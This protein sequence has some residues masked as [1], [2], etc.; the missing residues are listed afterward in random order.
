MNKAKLLAIKSF[1][2]TRIYGSRED[3]NLSWLFLQNKSN[4]IVPIFHLYIGKIQHRQFL[5]CFVFKLKQE[6][7]YRKQ[8]ARQLCT[9]IRQAIYRSVVTPWPWNRG[10]VKPFSLN[11]ETQRTV[12]V[13]HPANLCT[14][15]CI[16]LNSVLPIHSEPRK[17][18][19]YMVSCALWSFRII[20]VQRNLYQSKASMRLPI[21]LPL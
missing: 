3:G 7:I 9:T 12:R 13:T 19:G 16:S 17:S 11:T 20:Q 21:S 6:L 15:F 18:Y 4:W 14:N 2:V 8:I 10:Y 1:R 5:F